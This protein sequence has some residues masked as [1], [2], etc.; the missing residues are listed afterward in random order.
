MTIFMTFALLLF[1]GGILGMVLWFGREATSET[2]AEVAELFCESTLQA[3]DHEYRFG[4]SERMWARM[5]A[6]EDELRKRGFDPV[7][8]WRETTTAQYEG[9]PLDLGTCRA[10]SPIPTESRPQVIT[11]RR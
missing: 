4:S 5:S 3:S 7:K 1:L 10:G 2:D 8:I 11:H 6:Y 9:R